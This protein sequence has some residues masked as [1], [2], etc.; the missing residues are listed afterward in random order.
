M[1]SGRKIVFASSTKPYNIMS[2]TNA[3]DWKGR[4]YQGLDWF[5]P[6]KYH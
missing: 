1:S 4:G 2:I 5:S 3:Y 6:Y